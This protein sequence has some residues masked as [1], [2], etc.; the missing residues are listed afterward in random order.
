[1]CSKHK[2]LFKTPARTLQSLVR[3]LTFKI[4]GPNEEQLKKLA[5]RGKRI[6][7]CRRSW[8]GFFR[9]VDD[10]TQIRSLDHW[11]RRQVSAFMWQK[12]PCS[13]FKLKADAAA[14][15]GFPSLVNSLLW[16]ARSKKPLAWT[17]VAE[18]RWSLHRMLLEKLPDQFI[19]RHDPSN[20]PSFNLDV[21]FWTVLDKAGAHYQAGLRL[22]GEC[23]RRGWFPS[24]ISIAFNT[25]G[26][27]SSG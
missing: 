7:H 23:I 9:I 24:A 1:M 17:V 21:V 20:D 25:R 16:T 3:R 27:R 14:T 22:D 2:K 6:A 26:L 10:L 15:A 11:L 4:R 13:W 8:I 12:A 18:L 19:G 5:D